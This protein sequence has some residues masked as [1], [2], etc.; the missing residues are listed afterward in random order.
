MQAEKQ[1]IVRRDPWRWVRALRAFAFPLSILPVW[2]GTAAVLPPSEWHWG[3]LL[4]ANLAVLLLHSAGNLLNDYFDYLSGTDSRAE[5]DEGRP[6]RLL[7]HGAVSPRGIL[8]AA[9][10][11]LGLAACAAAYLVWRRGPVLLWFIGPAVFALYAYTGPPFRLK[12][13]AL[14]EVV[15]VVVFGPLIVGGAAYAQTGSLP[16]LAVWLLSVPVGMVTAS[17]LAGNNLRDYAEDRAAEV[18]TLAQSLGKR[19]QRVLY[20]SL[21]LGQTAGI[22]AFG[23]WDMSYPLLALSPVFLLLLTGT[24]RQVFRGRRVPDIDVRTTRFATALMAFLFFV[25]CVG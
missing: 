7:V 23:L 2:V 12:A 1:A 17:V 21:V 4:A 5:E 18:A 16:R 15:M 6:G 24:L 11:C 10:V 20:L 13:R 14:G 22:T 25:L 3:L 9:L 8:N 19:G